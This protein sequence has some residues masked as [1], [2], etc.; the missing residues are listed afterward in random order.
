LKLDKVRFNSGGDANRR[1]FGY[2]NVMSIIALLVFA[3]VSIVGYLLIFSNIQKGI[4]QAD[5]ESVKLVFVNVQLLQNFLLGIT[6]F[7]LFLAFIFIFN[8][9]GKK[10]KALISSLL[11]SKSKAAK[12]ARE[13]N[14]LITSLQKTDKDFR[15]INFALDSATA[16]IKTDKEGII[17]YA[18][19]RYCKTT[20]YAQEELISRQV[21]FNNQGGAESII[22][23]HIRDEASNKKLWQGEIY[24]NAKDGS[25]FWVDVTLIPIFSL[26]G[27]LYQ[28]LVICNDI[29]KRKEAEKR[30]Q[31]VTEERF[32]K[33][34]SEQK[35]R[36]N[37][38]IQGQE[39]ERKRMAREVHDGVGQMLTAL[40]FHTEALVPADEKQ[41]KNFESIKDLLQMV[42]REVRRISSALLPTVL[43]DFGLVAALKDMATTFNSLG[44]SVEL[45]FD[46]DI[47]E[48]HLD[49][50]IEISL[51]RI[52]QEAVN[53]A[54]KYAKAGKIQIVLNSDVEFLNLT[55]NDDG[56]GFSPEE[57]I[58]SNRYKST[59]NG[60][61]SMRERAELIEG[62]FSIV[63][64]PAS[65]TQIIVEVPLETESY[66]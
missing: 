7:L 4:E 42:I 36:S 29:T 43:S 61:T 9:L 30:L 55:I 48:E 40:K 24:D 15:D 5:S 27:E 52:A 6:L 16:L 33:E 17:I 34:L 41:G 66:E 62:N 57:K 22:Y 19:D 32:N 58:N 65:G 64:A 8:P 59:G 44:H 1:Q 53:N 37:S 2:F 54:L 35:D 60:L 10:I 11:S 25:S 45:V 21:F 31:I 14:A 26:K 39:Q 18:N 3:V 49:K 13:M 23:D 63:S 12:L 28:F 46:S 47:L 51:Y 20:K 56:I 50:T 38:V